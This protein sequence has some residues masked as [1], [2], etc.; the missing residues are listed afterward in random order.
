MTTS[1]MSPTARVTVPDLASAGEA[2]RAVVA[3]ADAAGL[4]P[5]AL[6]RVALIATE[7]ATNLARHGGGGWLLLR[8]NDTNEPRAIDVVA[9]DRGPG[10]ADVGRCLRDGFSTGG[11]RGEGLGAISR[12]ADLFELW[13]QAGKGAAVMARIVEPGGAPADNMPVGVVSVPLDHQPVSGDGWGIDHRPDA[14]TVC[15]VDGLGHGPV[16]HEAAQEA[17]RVFREQAGARPEETMRDLHQALIKTRGAAA[18]ICR[19]PRDGSPVRF[20]GIG[21]VAGTILTSEGR[22]GMLCHNGILGH[23]F[24]RVLANDYPAP[25]GALIVL[26]S[27]GLTNNWDLASYPGLAMRHPAIIAAILWR[28]HSRGRD[29][30]CVLVVRRGS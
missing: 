19:I 29:D 6:G 27:D 2:R 24:S 10:M 1:I 12:K 15:V 18:S 3:F 22:R 20:A 8:R 14:T 4:G 25:V 28:D 21:N 7:M 30:A 5:D 23:Q 17:I 13:S 26:H 11:S 16:A 9:V